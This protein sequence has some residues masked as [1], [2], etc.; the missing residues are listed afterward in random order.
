MILGLK[1][2][3][4]TEIGQAGALL[5]GGQRQRVALARA[6]IGKPSLV[7]M[8][9]AN[10]NL[11]QEGETAFIRC[12]NQLRDQGVSSIIVAHRR[13]L[14]SHC[15]K[16]LWLGDGKAVAFGETSKVMELIMHKA[17]AAE[18]TSHSAT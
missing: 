11:D 3:Y 15:D 1:D 2:G 13:A 8:D 16:L 17:S 6:V 5:S 10:A 9:E 7:V 18:S 14:L 12:L 4:R